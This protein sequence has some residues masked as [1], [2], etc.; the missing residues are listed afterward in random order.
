MH[1]KPIDCREVIQHILMS[2]DSN[3][4]IVMMKKK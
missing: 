2:N 3:D 4:D 1:N